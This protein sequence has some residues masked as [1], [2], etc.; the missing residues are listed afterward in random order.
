[1][2]TLTCSRSDLFPPGTAVTVHPALSKRDGQAPTA[3]SIASGTVDSAGALS[4]TDS[5]IVGYTG[6]VLYALVGSEHRY[7]FARSTLDT[8]AGPNATW[9]ATVAARRTAIGTS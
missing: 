5:D 3:A 2:A 9:K 1:M 4:I 8:H 7:A 6:F